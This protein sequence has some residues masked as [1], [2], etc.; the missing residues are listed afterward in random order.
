L[1]AIRIS[2]LYRDMPALI[3]AYRSSL[4]KAAMLSEITIPDR[5]LTKTGKERTMGMALSTKVWKWLGS[6]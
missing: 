6:P 1:V 2:Q 3:D 5:K 4:D